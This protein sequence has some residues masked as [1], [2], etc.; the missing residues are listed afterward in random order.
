MLKLV[1]P[2]P[3]KGRPNFY[4]R[5]TH[6]GRQVNQTAGTPV[7]RTAAQELARVKAQIERDR[8]RGPAA[9]DFLTAAIS[10]LDA[11]GE[12]RFIERLKNHFMETPLDQIDQAAI[13]RA[14][15]LLYPQA[16]AATRNRQVYTPVS[17]ILKHAGHRHAFARPKGAGGTPRLCWLT[18]EQANA[19]T[20][21]AWG[22]DARFGALM[23]FLFA[24]GCRLSEALELAP[25]RL[26]LGRATAWVGRTKNG[27]PRMV[28][29]PPALV[30]AL[31]NFEHG[32]LRVFG[33]YK[34][35]PLYAKL[36]RA[37]K[38]AGVAIPERV[39]FHICR[40]T[41]ATMMR[42][43]AGADTR[44]LVATGA[45]KSRQAAAVY[46]HVDPSEEARRADLLPLIMPKVG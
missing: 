38:A 32:D 21:A 25:D 8:F 13:D 42:R 1:P 39:A 31:A 26:D 29:L 44:A 46:E 22:L 41:W 18:P 17:A 45:W 27:E 10:Y 6:F 35:A 43:Y 3:A 9:P 28:H 15:V 4:I 20:A 24:T 5:G 12:G 37:A 36:D 30:A 2:N 7:R 11:G 40:H 19:L 34:G 14:A 33:L 16:D 23:A